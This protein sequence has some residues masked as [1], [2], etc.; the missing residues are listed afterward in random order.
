M[1]KRIF[2]ATLSSSLNHDEEVKW[3]EA[4]I[5]D[6]LSKAS[7]P[8]MGGALRNRGLTT[9]HVQQGTRASSCCLS[10]FSSTLASTTFIYVQ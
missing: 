5:H 9:Q 2:R 7:G 3:K 10:L 8:S 4:C 1:G 6:D